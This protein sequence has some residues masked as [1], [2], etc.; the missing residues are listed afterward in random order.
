MVRGWAARAGRWLRARLRAHRYPLV[1]VGIIFIA[2]TVRV[3]LL[4]AGWPGTDSDDATMGLMAKHILTRGEHP[5]FFYGQSYMGAVEAYLG[6]LMFALFGVSQL[7]LKC[8]LVVLYAGF[9][10]VMYALLAQL[11]DR[12]WA[13]IGLVLLAFGADDMLYHQLEAYGGYLETL[14]FGALLLALATWLVRTGTAAK[15]ARR[16]LTFGMWGLAA[17]LGLWSDP[18][19]A[20]FVALSALVLVLLCWRDVRG[21]AGAIALLGLMLGVVPWIIYLVTVPSAGMARG[22]LQQPVQAGTSANS[23]SVA[24]QPSLQALGAAVFKQALGAVLISVPNNT[25]ATTLCPLRVTQ[26]W[27]PDQWTTPHVRACMALRTVWGGGFLTLLGL[28]LVLEV[29]ALWALWALRRWSTKSWSPVERRGVARSAGR[30]M[31]LAAPAGT[32]MLYALSS[33][34]AT[35]PWQYSRYLISLAIALPV[36]LATLWDHAGRARRRAA[37]SAGT[38]LRRRRPSGR[39]EVAGVT[40]LCAVVL[41][42]GTVGAYR[43]SAA[44][45]AQTQQQEDLARRLLAQGDTRV[46]SEFWTCYRLMFE[47]DERVVC[48]VLNADLSPRPSRWALYDTM[49]R[50]APQPAYVF[51][52]PSPQASLFPQLAAERGWHIVDAT[53]VDGQWIIFHV[54]SAL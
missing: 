29:R 7:A 11:F 38:L 24:V 20:P 52:L 6:A 42:V 51:P 23:I 27:P 47:S 15:R 9:M 32:V 53:M 33:S 17:G 5:I 2:A 26:A 21:R 48:G 41:I 34:A 3:G 46:Y 8:G 19:V 50:A 35:A 14:F 18:L 4:V 25:G 44:A 49:M 36:A 16:L 12:R 1:A 28:A 30:A 39:I 13:L 31:A 22:F 43:A 45:S 37:K 10:A 40:S 54:Q